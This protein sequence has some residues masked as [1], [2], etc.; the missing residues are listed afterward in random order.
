MFGITMTDNILT[1]TFKSFFNLIFFKA[2]GMFIFSNTCKVS[3]SL[4]VY[5]IQ[6]LVQGE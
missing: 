4:W 2:Q 5:A 6:L 1:G 3:K